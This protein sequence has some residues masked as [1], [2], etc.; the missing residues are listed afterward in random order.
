MHTICYARCLLHARSMLYAH[1]LLMHDTCTCTMLDMHPVSCCTMLLFLHPSGRYLCLHC[2]WMLEMPIICM[3]QT[4]AYA[5]IVRDIGVHDGTGCTVLLKS[6]WVC[7][8]MS[9]TRS[10]ILHP[11]YYMHPDMRRASYDRARCWECT[12]EQGAK[13][14][15]GAVK[16]TK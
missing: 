13:S 12:R 4:Y 3:L 15:L 11:V 10:W 14:I 2:E 5:Y 9:N 16:G 8:D 1:C 7:A 6:K